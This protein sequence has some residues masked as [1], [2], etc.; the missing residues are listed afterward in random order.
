MT[1][2][3]FSLLILS[4]LTWAVADDELN[5]SQ[6]RHVYEE[7]VDGK[8]LEVDSTRFDNFIADLS[9]SKIAVVSVNGMVCDFCARGLEKTF[10]RDRSVS[11][12]DVDLKNGKVL[13]AYRNTKKIDFS[14]I[15]NRILENGQNVTDIQVLEV[16]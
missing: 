16:K 5:E 9:D 6:E 15:R 7:L 11:K 12:I 10:K 14:D 2:L 13:I 3:F 4:S 8:N 1:K